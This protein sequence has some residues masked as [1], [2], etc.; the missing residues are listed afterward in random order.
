MTEN[1][2]ITYSFFFVLLITNLYLWQNIHK[3]EKT[4]ANVPPVPSNNTASV[5]T[6]G[7][8]QLAYRIYAIMLQNIG[9]IGG[10]TVSLK[11]YNYQDLK[12]WFFLQHG[13]DQKSNIT[14]MLAA[15]Y[16]GAIEEPEKLDAVFDYLTLVGSDPTGEKWRWLGHAVFL[17]KHIMKDNNKA[18]ELANKLAQNKNPD[19]A[20][21]AKQMP[22]F[23]LQEQGQS[24]LAY[25]IMLNI[26][27]SNIDT[28]HPSEIF[29]MKEYICL[30]LL[31]DLPE[32]PK[33]DFCE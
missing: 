31:P 29:Y 14:P 4:W 19:L 7:D 3:I 23:I 1:R 10:K 22:A 26:L 16:F 27:I 6:L 17:A 28:L 24:E 18:L 2:I 13:L 12:K 20:D 21:W 9:S 8:K 5:I 25:K 11:D 32:T 30:T 15:Q 33:P